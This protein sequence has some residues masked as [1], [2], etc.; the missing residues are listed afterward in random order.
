MP[1]G[2]MRSVVLLVVAACEVHDA[3]AGLGE[4][5]FAIGVGGHDGPVAGQCEAKRLHQ[6][7]H[8][9]GGEHSRTGSAGGAGGAFHF[10]GEFVGDARVGG[11]DHGV[12]QIHGP[13]EVA[14]LHLACLHGSAG[15]EDG[16]N[17][18]A[19]GRHQHAGRNF[20]AI[21]DA[22]QGVGAVRVCHV[23]DAVGDQFPGGQ[24]VQHAAVAHGDAVIHGDGVELLGDSAGALD[25]RGDELSE[26]LQVDVAGHELGEG[27][28]DGDDGLAEIS[29]FH[30]GGAPQAARAGHVAAVSGG[31]RAINGHVFLRYQPG[32]EGRI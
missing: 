27:V 17:V 28:G 3:A 9:V 32:G 1:R 14:L 5:M 20:V 19:E 4:E 15:D 7:V 25:F 2:R 21:G 11:G 18:E 8:R 13:D 26:V 30:S 24:A 23:L 31:A 22:H 6:A 12:H 29:V 10:G 16:G